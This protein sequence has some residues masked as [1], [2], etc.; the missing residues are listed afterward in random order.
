[1]RWRIVLPMFQELFKHNKHWKW[2][3]AKELQYFRN[4]MPRRRAALTPF[5]L[6]AFAEF[7]IV[8]VGLHKDDSCCVL[9]TL[10]KYDLTPH[11][12]QMSDELY[13]N[14][15]LDGKS[16]LRS[17]V[18]LFN[19]IFRSMKE[20]DTQAQTSSMYNLFTNSEWLLLWDVT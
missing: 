4:S 6:S 11:T 16:A 3:A 18:F 5:S 13:G 1:M 8:F 9:F 7:T 20:Q 19:W 17:G 14:I 12:W 2:I 10:S 15:W